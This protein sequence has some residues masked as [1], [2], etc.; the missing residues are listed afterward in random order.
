L[1][2]APVVLGRYLAEHPYLVPTPDREWVS[3][4]RL[5]DGAAFTHELTAAE[6]ASGM[7]SA[8]DDLALWAQFA[9]GGLPLA[10]GGAVR[11]TTILDLPPGIGDDLP[12]GQGMIGQLLTGPDGWLAGFS[13]G[14]L[15]LVR[16]RDGALEI[17]ERKL[18]QETAGTSRLRDVCAF[19]AV[20]AVGAVCRGNDR[21]SVCATARD[22][23]R[24]DAR[25][26]EDLR[27]A[28]AAGCE[29]KTEIPAACR[30][31]LGQVPAR[32]SQ[33]TVPRGCGPGRGRS[34]A[35]SRGRC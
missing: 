7:L 12:A 10:G 30:I 31:T 32:P 14:D 17:S 24:P 4:L 18:P 25:G 22:P 19:A 23:H 1:T 20:G 26:A 6:V 28:D 13:A 11:A 3:G 21:P 29:L 5:A 27:V 35:D 34:A 15:L 33:V 8:D 2:V 16:L 9:I